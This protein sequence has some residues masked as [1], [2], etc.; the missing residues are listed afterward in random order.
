MQVPRG[1]QAL[2]EETAAAR[3]GPRDPRPSGN[4]SGPGGPGARGSAATGP[5]LLAGAVVALDQTSKIWAVA[6]L[7]DGPVRLIGDTLMLRLTRNP[8]GAFSLLTGFTPLLAVLAGVMVVVI[9][10]TARRTDDLAV[11]YGLG[12]VLGGALGNLVDRVARDPGVLSGH[13]VDFIKV[14]FFNWPTF[15]LADCAISLGVAV[16]LLRSA[17]S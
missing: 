17:R 6:A 8:G 7:A 1:A 5:F 12:L 9:V 2:T 3:S 11:A 14:S 4:D 16:I 13:V 10:R 15:N